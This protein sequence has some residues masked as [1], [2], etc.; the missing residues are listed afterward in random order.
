ML[1]RLRA[2][3]QLSG[4]TSD[5]LASAP[6]PPA[7]IDFYG[8]A[9]IGSATIGELAC[10]PAMLRETLDLVG[11]VAD[12]DYVAHVRGFV[13]TARRAAGDAWRYADITTVLAAATR[14][15]RPASYLEIGVRRGRSAAVVGAGAPAC[16]IVAVDMW[17][18]GYAGMDNPGPAHLRD[19][20]ARAGHRGEIRV[21]SGDSHVELPRLFA[22]EPGLTFDLI[23][24]DGDHS[25]R[26]ARRDLE[27]VLPR[28][29]IGGALVF[30]DVSHPAH[31]E[32]ARVWERT[33]ASERRYATWA[34]DD[35]GYG[36]AVAVRRW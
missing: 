16:S 32:L 3:R 4:H 2:A 7:G 18:E 26:G 6:D 1:E 8:A 31:P 30:D 24:V 17:N 25:T 35:V 23:T 11:R 14:L 28:L 5:R 12:D 27:D 20:L 13:D 29:R 21:I 19:V 10:D 15:L 33:V 36:V 22:T 9:V 34:Y